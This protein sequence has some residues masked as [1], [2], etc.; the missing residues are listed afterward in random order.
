MPGWW[1]GLNGTAFG[2]RWERLQL[3]SG[4]GGLLV[5]AL[6]GEERA[7]EPGALTVC[8]W[9]SQIVVLADAWEFDA[10]SKCSP[11]LLLTMQAA[12]CGFD[13][14]FAY[15][16]IDFKIP[17]ARAALRLQQKNMSLWCV[18]SPV[19]CRVIRSSLVHLSCPNVPCEHGM[20]GLARTLCFKITIPTPI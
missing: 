19:S 3:G 13:F 12:G 20:G 5:W 11:R 9:A 16:P 8:S 10:I 18:K 15:S 17:V 7:A 6:G 2:W 14:R 1:A 4:D